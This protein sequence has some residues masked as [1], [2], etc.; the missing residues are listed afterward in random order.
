MGRLDGGKGLVLRPRFGL[1][2]NVAAALGFFAFWI[3]CRDV[4]GMGFESGSALV[5]AIALVMFL[6][7]VA[8]RPPEIRLRNDNIFVRRFWGATEVDRK[9]YLGYT[10]RRA[11]RVIGGDSNSSGRHLFISH[12]LDSG[13]IAVT[14]AFWCD[15]LCGLLS[16]QEQASF[17]AALDLWHSEQSAVPAS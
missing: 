16:V 2:L 8:I 3:A 14:P 6:I 15:Q 12:R 9:H 13:S 17:R 1:M 11:E 10:F 4:K 5:A 7:V